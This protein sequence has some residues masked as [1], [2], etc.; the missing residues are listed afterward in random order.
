MA[1]DDFPA[2][3][4][5][6]LA[7]RVAYRCSNPACPCV[8][9]GPSSVDEEIVNLGVAAHIT[10]AAERGPRY[11]GSLSAA[12]RASIQNGIWLCQSC[13]ALIDRDVG[14]YPV[15]LLRQWKQ[16]AERAAFARQR[17]TSELAGT[18][19]TAPEVIEAVLRRYC[20]D[21][22]SDWEEA[23]SDREDPD[24]LPHY[25]E[26]HYSLLKQGLRPVEASSMAGRG[27]DEPE[28][29]DDPYQP[30]AGE[31]DDAVAELV[32]LLNSSQRLCIAE[33]AGAGKSIFTRRLLAFLCSREGQQALFD[34]QPCL[35]VRWEQRVRSWPE[36][37]DEGGLVTALTKAVKATV[38]ATGADVSPTEVAE[39]ALREGRVFLI[40]DALDQVPNKQSVA[41]LEE[42]MHTGPAQKCHIVL[43]SR[44]YAVT[45]HATLFHDTRGWKFGRIDGFDVDQQK[46]YLVNLQTGSLEAL[47]AHEQIEGLLRTPVVLAMIRELAEAG[48]LKIFRKRGDLY[49]QVHE[50]LTARAARKLCLQPNS[51]QL[52]RWCEVLAA[53]ACEMM[54]KG[55]YNYAVQ[56]SFAVH[57]VHQGASDRCKQSITAEEWRV[58]ESVSGLTDRCILE[59]ATS[60]NLCWKHRGMME[61]YCGLHLARNSQQGWVVQNTDPRGREWVRCG[62]EKVR[63]LA[64]DQEWYWAWRFAIEMAPAVWQSQPS[65]L[66]ASLSEF[67][68]RPTSGA[69]PN[70][71]ICRAWSLLDGNPD[72]T[73]KIPNGAQVIQ[74]FQQEF[75]DLL[76]GQNEV[77]LGL[78]KSFV[79]CPPEELRI[80]KQP[81][82]MGAEEGDTEGEADERPWHQ[83]VVSPFCLQS[84]PVTRAQYR[85]YDH[86]HESVHCNWGSTV[87]FPEYAPSDDC[88]MIMV[89]WYDAWVFARWL[90]GRLP[91]EA[92]WEYACRAGST[93]KYSF[94]DSESQLGKYA[95]YDNNASGKTHRVGQR[96]K[97]AWG[98]YD[99]HGNVHEWCQDWFDAGYYA[100]SPR[101]DPLGPKETS[102]RVLRGGSW[103]ELAGACRAAYRFWFGPQRRHIALGFR[104]AA[105][106]PGGQSRTSQLAEPGA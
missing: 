96:R 64:R 35:A 1:R 48:K 66:L 95:W 25:V 13:A 52:V 90:G 70:E 92:E 103:D 33:D 106:P 56:G 99:M 49:L 58:I 45:D 84:T 72:D 78:Q 6:I 11:D 14:M 105:V 24:K 32:K 23:R 79:R 50:H 16:Q 63:R 37:F 30:V 69:R 53:T 31:G 8:T 29:R 18:P 10:A 80:D 55:R 61:F 17:R 42:S 28:R 65:T 101:V 5:E 20:E 7:K 34:G 19:T 81:F 91:T 27:G 62:D 40:L 47:A 100:T 26:P 76:K 74:R 4:K 2:P 22:V 15:A 59:G 60:E 21:R 71:L 89:S 3:T 39:W 67:F 41:S 104:V 87:A 83:V 77:A 102:L 85:L 86:V 88:P 12:E 94:G 43:T 54:A 93:G 44:A 75:R 98:L 38:E 46:Q 97:N 73:A 36:S 51:D 9:V 68:E 57:D 82:W